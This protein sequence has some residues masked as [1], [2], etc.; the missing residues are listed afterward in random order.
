MPGP[1][2][3]F[4]K[5]SSGEILHISK[6]A[7]GIHC[8]CTCPKCDVPLI[9]RTEHA[10]PHFA[11][12][13]EAGSGTAGC[14][15]TGQ[16]TALH[17][18]ARDL[19][20]KGGRVRLP[21][22]SQDGHRVA[23][24]TEVDLTD[25]RTE[26]RFDGHQPDVVFTASGRPLLMEIAVTHPV[27]PSK[28]G[29]IRRQR[30]EAFE[31]D[32]KPKS[33]P[34]SF[35]PE[36]VENHVRRE[37]PRRWIFNESLE[38]HLYSLY[39][40]DGVQGREQLT[41]ETSR[42]LAVL[43]DRMA[44]L[45]K[46][47]APAVAAKKASVAEWLGDIRPSFEGYFRTASDDWRAF[48]LLECM[49]GLGLPLRRIVNRLKAAE[50][51]HVDLLRFASSKTQSAE[52]G[53]PA[54]GVEACVFTFLSDLEQRGAVVCLPG[55]N[56]RLLVELPGQ[57]PLPFGPLPARLTR[58]ELTTMRHEEIEGILQR[59]AA[60]LSPTDSEEFANGIGAWWKR[61]LDGS[62][63]PLDIIT[64]GNYR[65]DRLKQQLVAIDQA[66]SSV[67]PDLS[68][69]LGLPM[70]EAIAAHAARFLIVEREKG[71]L[72]CE[73]LQERALEKF[74]T[75]IGAIWLGTRPSRKG[76]SPRDLAKGSEAGLKA[77][78]EALEYRFVDKNRVCYFQEKFHTWT[79]KKF[80]GKG[81]RFIQK[82]N[83]WLPDRR[84]PRQ[85]CFDD[86]SSR[87]MQELTNLAMEFA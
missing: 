38:N 85:C 1:T 68:N 8:H 83:D 55:G 44:G 59:I 35:S 54:F 79:E 77:S 63:T 61:T 33:V 36:A 5:H 24:L 67:T 53:L 37:A 2:L 21:D 78:L 51:L 40:L 47:P 6:A 7:N 20:L 28:A 64:V 18:F 27:L 75:E 30:V 57:Q 9:A 70:S 84:T 69:P 3:A 87:A 32:I 12:R 31:I 45:P 80:R 72:R 74:G 76:L 60:H 42:A 46:V 56:W 82:K 43:Y 25:V 11:H 41:S 81:L 66:L 34:G 73:K 29:L 15:T 26:Q 39:H 19:F 17:T 48:V 4:G 50:H 14:G 10:T 49:N 22:L 13:P 71:L 23:G 58:S 65:F 86:V 16:M 62:S 52:A